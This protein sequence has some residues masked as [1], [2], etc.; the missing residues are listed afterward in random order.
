LKNIL[1]NKGKLFVIVT[2]LI[3]LFTN[4]LTAQATR[5]PI[6]VI[7]PKVDQDIGSVDSTFILGNIESPKLKNEKYILFINERFIDIHEDGGFLAFLPIQPGQF[8]FKFDVFLVD[9]KKYRNLTKS[10]KINNI[11]NEDIKNEIKYRHPVNVPVPL[12]STP[13]DSLRIE[14]VISPRMSKISLTSGERLKFTIKGTPYCN[15][16]MV[17]DG[18]GDSI[19]M[20]ETEPSSQPYWGEALFGSGSVPDSLLIKG[21]YTTFI[22]IPHGIV[23]DSLIAKFYLKPPVYGEEFEINQPPNK[24]EF[25]YYNFPYTKYSDTDIVFQ[26][27]TFPISINNPDFPMTVKFIDSV[28]TIRHGPRMGYF[29]IFQPKGVEALAVG[30]YGDWYICQLSPNQKAWVLKESVES[31]PK[32]ILP[33]HSYLS[34]V[35]FKSDQNKVVLEFPLKGKHPFRIIEEDKRNLKI[36]LFGV[37]SNTDWIRYVSTESLI[38]IATWSQPDEK[39]YQLDI[40]LTKDIWGYDSFYNGNTFYFLINKNPENVKS[41]KGKT[42]IIDPGHSSDPGSIGPTGYTEAEANLGIALKLRDKL[43]SKGANVIMT[44]DNNSHVE[45]YDRPVIAKQNDADLFVSIHNNALPDGVNPFVNFGSSTYYYHPHSIDLARTIQGELVAAT[46]LGDYGL[47][48]GNLAVNR[49]TQYPA[50]L[51]ECAFMILPAQ[52][53]LLKTDKFRNNVA[54]AITKGIENFL[55]QY[56]KRNK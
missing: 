50:V 20:I 12:K 26:E 13:S 49:P 9:K 24:E 1:Q 40:T 51:V 15:A 48:H 54:K 10:S 28:Q 36:Q 5:S 56:D 2:L 39:L 8:E 46:K 27:F 37:T 6:S 31:K 43:Q 3:M 42:I 45:L 52:E 32:G 19:P 4:L 18:I 14:E 44:R 25:D 21:I 7:Y 41:L 23:S 47:Y 11:K 38:E 33:P 17:I 55:K 53:A 35:R 16:W 30:E 34:V 29:S 22:D